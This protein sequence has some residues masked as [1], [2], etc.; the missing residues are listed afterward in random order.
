[1]NHIIGIDLGTT[2]SSAAFYDK[3]ELTIIPNSRGSRIT[4]SAVAIDPSGE[5]LVGESARNQAVVNPDATVLN[6]KRRMGSDHLYT[7][8]GK[9]Y[10]P[11]EISSFIL[12]TLKKDCENYLGETVTEA[13]IT[14]PAYFNEKQRK[15]TI[16]AGR[17]AGLKVRKIIN[18]PTSSALI[19][20]DR[21]KEDR[22]L[23]VYDLGG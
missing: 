19:F 20:A 10:S 22:T 12:K 2:N 17:L 14:V 8:H 11:Q 18:E 4:P 15:A 5:I 13:V 9:G 1:L 23:L 21:N 7:I 3:R 6:V 16:E